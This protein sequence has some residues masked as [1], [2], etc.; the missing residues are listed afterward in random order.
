MTAAMPAAAAAIA[1]EKAKTLLSLRRTDLVPN[2]RSIRRAG[3]STG[4]RAVISFR[5]RIRG[6]ADRDAFK[7]TNNGPKRNYF[8]PRTIWMSNSRIFLR[9]VF[10]FTP[11][12]SAALI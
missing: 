12:N 2:V 4:S 5:F 7:V 9:N 8:T 11:S 1:R 3:L 10:R 6:G